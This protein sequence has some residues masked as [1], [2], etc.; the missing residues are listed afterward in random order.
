MSYKRDAKRVDRVIRKSGVVVVMNKDHVKCPECT[1]EVNVDKH[2]DVVNELYELADS[3][4]TTVEMISTDSE[5]GEMLVKAF[6]GLA[7][8]LRYRIGG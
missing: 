4:G 6:N 7:A 2:I 3:Y 8:I 1:A 5:E